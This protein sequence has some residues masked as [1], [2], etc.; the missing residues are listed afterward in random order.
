MKQFLILLIV[1]S[2]CNAVWAQVTLR[3]Q[4]C[5]GCSS[6]E[7]GDAGTN[8]SYSDSTYETVDITSDFG[9]RYNNYDWHKGVDFR[10]SVYAGGMITDEGPVF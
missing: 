7:N 4:I 6:Q 5:T 9:P 3:Y 2:G 1:L 10:P 8:F